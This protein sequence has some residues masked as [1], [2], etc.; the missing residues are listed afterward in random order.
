ML[1][2][3]SQQGDAAAR[4]AAALA[5]EW[6]RPADS[7]EHPNQ[8][9]PRGHVLRTLDAAGADACLRARVAAA[10]E[11]DVFVADAGGDFF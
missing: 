2:L 7:A 8:V 11:P 4:E 5:E 6:L 10:P 1:A 3:A 9:L